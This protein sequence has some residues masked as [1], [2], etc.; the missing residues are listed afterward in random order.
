MPAI[1]PFGNQRTLILGEVNTGKTRATIAILSRW[2]AAHPTPLMTVL[3]LAPETVRGVGGR[4]KPPA[5]FTGRYCAADIVAPRLT[6]RNDDQ[7]SRLA[8]ANAKAVKPILE[9]ILSNPHPIL[10]INDVTLY[11]QA[12]DYAL[13]RAVLNSADT[14]LINAYYGRSF[15]DHPISRRERRLTERLIRDCDCV[16][17]MPEGK[18]TGGL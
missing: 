18:P 6:G 9:D 7:I 11:L 14:A 4:L 13:L 2:V 16:I 12:G 10:I 5:G 8:T 17:R 3:D 1:D 15:A